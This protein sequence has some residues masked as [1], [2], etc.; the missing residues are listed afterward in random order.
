MR[1]PILTYHSMH[2]SGNSVEDNDH[3]SLAADLEVIDAAGFRI[4]PLHELVT[5][6]LEEPSQLEDERLVALTC[7][8]GP[9]FDYRDL[10][11]P[12]HGMQRSMLNILLDF[13]QSKPGA[14]PGLFLTSFVIVSPSARHE[15]DRSCM[16][17]KGWWND[18]W[19]Q[20]AIDTGVMGIASH[21]WDHNH[22]ALASELFPDVERGTFTTIGTEILADYQIRQASDFLWRRAPNPSARIF[23][24]PYGPHSD[25]LV[26]EYLP[27]NSAALHLDAAVA[28]LP[29]PWTQTSNRW[30]IPRYVHPRDWRD[31]DG[32]MRLL[33]EFT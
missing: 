16:I 32:L 2:M 11:H 7:D 31:P 1:I 15:L 14:Q 29:E 13:R 18:T 9:D 22:D 3:K 33:E 26:N 30:E 5:K 21:S 27:R 10:E 25:Y 17:G 8:D 4:R 24:Y 20:A 6:W 19:W 23:A 28:H 12:V